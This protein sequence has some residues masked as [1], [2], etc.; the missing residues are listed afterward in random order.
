[1]PTVGSSNLIKIPASA[2][3]KWPQQTPVRSVG[4][5]WNR[6]YPDIVLLCRRLE[7]LGTNELLDSPS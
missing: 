1:M 7:G 5:M 2:E 6:L 3:A 4:K